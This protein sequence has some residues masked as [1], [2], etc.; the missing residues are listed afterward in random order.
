[1]RSLHFRAE[2]DADAFVQF[3]GLDVQNAFAPLVERRRACSIS[4]LMGWLRTSGAACLACRLA[5]V[6]RVQKN[7]AA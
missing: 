4:Q 5:L 3:A 2:D 1:M 7:P 6:P